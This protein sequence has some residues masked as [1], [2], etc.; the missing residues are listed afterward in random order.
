[1]RVWKIADFGLS[2]EGT[3]TRRIATQYSRGTTG[4]RAPELLKEEAAYNNKVDIWALGCILYEIATRRKAF[5]HDPRLSDVDLRLPIPPLPLDT[6]STKCL[7]EMINATLD[8][9]WW[10]RPSTKDI[11]KVLYLL[12]S[13][14]PMLGLGNE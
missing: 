10:R 14:S 1:M 3:S 4:Y 2:S 8:V 11:L 12:N 6:R 7:S 5:D 9:D 13:T